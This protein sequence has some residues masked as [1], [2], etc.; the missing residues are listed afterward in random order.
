MAPLDNG[1]G[2][3]GAVIRA[4]D[5]SGSPVIKL[6]GEIDIS[7][8]DALGAQLDRMVGDSSDCVVIDLAALEFM[9]SSGIAM[10]IRAASRT[11]FVE[12]RSPSD[13]VRRIIEYTGLTDVLRIET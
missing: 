3:L 7:N 9:D 2:E 1:A 4:T 6:I 5:A 13:A 12:I 10:L 11:G 8:A